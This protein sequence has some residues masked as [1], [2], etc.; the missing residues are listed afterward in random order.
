LPLIN[1]ESL[2]HPLI[3]IYTSTPEEPQ[4]QGFIRR[5]ESTP[6]AEQNNPAKKYH[7]DFAV[8]NFEGENT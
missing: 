4:K 2:T 5:A 8:L 6:Q 7:G 3:Y 1:A